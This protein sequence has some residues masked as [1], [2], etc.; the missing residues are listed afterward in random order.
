MLPTIADVTILSEEVESDQVY[1]VVQ[2]YKV[3]EDKPALEKNPADVFA[4]TYLT[5]ALKT[6]LDQIRHKLTGQDRRGGLVVTGGYGSGKSHQLLALYHTLC[7]PEL[8]AEWLARQGY[9]ASLPKLDDLVVIVLHTARVDYDNLWEPVFQQLGAHDALDQVKRYPT[10]P[11]IRQ[12][13]S[14]RPVVII[15]DEI[16]NWYE[17]ILPQQAGSSGTSQAANR[18][19]L[20]HL[21]EVANEPDVPLMVLFSLIRD[22]PDIVDVIDRTEPISINLSTAA[23][24]E[25]IV[26]YRLFAQV[27]RAKV[28]QVVDHFIDLYRERQ[29]PVPMS[30]YEAYRARMA[31]VYPLHPELLRVLFERYS[32]ASNYANTRGILY[33]LAAILREQATSTPILLAS[34]VDAVRFDD[35]LVVLDRPLVEATVRDIERVSHVEYGRDILSTVLLYSINREEQIGADEREIVIGVATPD[36]N[37]NDVLLGLNRLLGQ[38]WHLHKLNGQ[39]AVRIEENVFAVVQNRA[40]D[41]SDPAAIQRIAQILAKDVLGGNTYVYDI[42]E[43]HDDRHLKVVVSLRAFETDQDVYAIYH[44]HRYQNRMVV[45]APLAGD[46]GKDQSL[47]DKAKRIIGG[48]EIKKDVSAERAAKVQDIIDEELGEL[49][50]RLKVRFGFWAKVSVMVGEGPDGQRIEKEAVRKIQVE[51]DTAKL[52]QRAVSDLARVKEKTLDVLH[53][54]GPKGLRADLLY[55]DFYTIRR[56][57]MVSDASQLTAALK[58]LCKEEQVYIEGHKGRNFFGETP[59]GLDEQSRA[60]LYHADFAQVQRGPAG[61]AEE[62]K[63]VYPAREEPRRPA[64]EPRPAEALAGVEVT[65]QRIAEQLRLEEGGKHPRTVAGKFEA[66]LRESDEIQHVKVEISND[67]SV[68]GKSDKLER[69]VKEL[70][71]SP[72][73]LKLSLTLEWAGP[74]EKGPFLQQLLR[75]PATPGG[76][77]YVMAEVDRVV[78]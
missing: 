73:E 48:E 62:V 70:G 61:E 7:H 21:L 66:T 50:E 16:E 76:S 33:L 13:V 67:F 53:E 37:P 47:I 41:I 17:T 2:L 24:R 74:L 34:D 36:I 22:N 39:Y 25:E 30:D 40:R 54:R 52:L 77:L 28:A 26:L 56:Y 43:I 71:F 72:E 29:I 68:S 15:V 38:A 78:E 19:F 75:L 58:E 35:Q 8:A 65:P 44:G 11:Q 4:R 64:L 20:Q 45:L 60:M 10:I 6:A 46:V 14:G 63:I 59:Y 12:A 1:G 3:L 23:D 57:P 69:I 18:T 31:R 42:D 9:D 49:K 5:D 55:S 32:T 51:A 27:D